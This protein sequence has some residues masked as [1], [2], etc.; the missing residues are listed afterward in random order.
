[1]Q[2]PDSS[3]CLFKFNMTNSVSESLVLN[4]NSNMWQHTD[5]NTC[6][7]ALQSFR[8]TLQI[9]KT[10]SLRSTLCI[11]CTDACP[12]R[13]LSISSEGPSR[14][15]H[16]EQYLRHSQHMYCIM[17]HTYDLNITSDSS[18]KTNIMTCVS[19]GVIRYIKNRNPSLWFAETESFN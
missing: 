9:L 18:L 8:D 17:F 4:C 2:I 15:L 14:K 6:R 19:E 12:C 11:P 10:P 16:G 5:S 1:M 13:E 3:S 7:E